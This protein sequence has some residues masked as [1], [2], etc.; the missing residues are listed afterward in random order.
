MASL[1]FAFPQIQPS[2][3][4]QIAGAAVAASPFSFAQ[5]WQ[6]ADL[7]EGACREGQQFPGGLE[8]PGA[9]EEEVEVRTQSPEALGVV[10]E[11]VE[12]DETTWR[13]IP[14]CSIQIFE[15]SA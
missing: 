15:M 8:V 2:V 10:E 4:R 1:P 5:T 3:A 14:D 13:T 12:V 7:Q 6:R 11:G 9:E